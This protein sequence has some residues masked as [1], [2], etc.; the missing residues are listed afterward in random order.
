MTSRLDRD[1]Y[2]IIKIKYGSEETAVSIP[3]IK[4]FLI[5]KGRKKINELNQ[6]E[7]LI[8]FQLMSK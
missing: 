6:K 8:L 2:R 4:S 3:E 1:I 5:R 7:K